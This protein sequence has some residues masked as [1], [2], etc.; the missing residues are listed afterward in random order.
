MRIYH[1]SLLVTFIMIS[2]LTFSKGKQDS[3]KAV[4]AFEEAKSLQ[5]KDALESRKITYYWLEVAKANKWKE[6][7]A[8]IALLH[9]QTDQVCGSA[10]AGLHTLQKAV[11]WSEEIDSNSLILAEALV[12]SAKARLLTG[13]SDIG[14]EEALRAKKIYE[15]HQLYEHQLWCDAVKA[16]CY[17]GQEMTEKAHNLAFNTVNLFEKL[18]PSLAQLDAYFI[19]FNSFSGGLLEPALKSVIDTNTFNQRLDIALKMIDRAYLTAESLE[20]DVYKASALYHKAKLFYVQNKLDSAIS[21]ARQTYPVFE[22]TNYKTLLLKAKY[23]EGL[24]LS[25]SGKYEEAIDFLIPLGKTAAENGWLVDLLPMYTLLANCYYSLGDLEKGAF[26]GSRAYTFS[27]FVIKDE[28]NLKIQA[29]EAQYERERQERIAAQNALDASSYSRWMNTFLYGAISLLIVLL[30]FIFFFI[31]LRKSKKV[32]ERKNEIIAKASQKNELLLKEIHHR[33]KNNLQIISSLLKLQIK[34]IDDEDA[35]NA[36]IEG[37]NRVKSMSLI[38]KKL[39]Q[40]EN[41]GEINFDD[42]LNDLLGALAH[43]FKNEK[44]EVD[45]TTDANGYLFDIDTAIPLGLIVN[46]LVSNAFKYATV[47]NKKL[48]LIVKITK[49]ESSG[50]YLL[51]VTDNGPGMPSEFSIEKTKSLGLRLVS[52]LSRQLGGNYRFENLEQGCVFFVEFKDTETRKEI[53]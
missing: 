28:R 29:L 33:V 19:Y 48:I 15:F 13:E 39:Y 11:K 43:T 6:L 32:L 38:H 41:L 52:S 18:T 9:G 50:H 2:S 20:N 24:C 27:T 46:E 3:I 10:E 4:K 25:I 17:K 35:T 31:K 53:L 7:A 44:T 40:N 1:F 26:Y 12:R 45:I 30:F 5:Y 16:A 34:N 36:M 42:Y 47:E 8:K 14:V 23:L 51:T 49:K 37:Q 21:T 22:K